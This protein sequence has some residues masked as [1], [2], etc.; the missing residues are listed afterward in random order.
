MIM[1][2]SKDFRK[3]DIY[4]DYPY[5]HAKF[6][7]DKETEKVYRRFYGKRE[8]Q[9]DHTSDLFNEAIAAGELITRDAYFVDYPSCKAVDAVLRLIRWL[10]P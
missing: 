1:L 9:I 3:G 4:I 10:K 7:W 2:T 5:E 6:R 8:T